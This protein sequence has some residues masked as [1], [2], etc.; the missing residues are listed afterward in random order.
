VFYSSALMTKQAGRM[1]HQFEKECINQM[2]RSTLRT[3]LG[4]VNTK[5]DMGQRYRISIQIG[6][7][8][9]YSKYN[10]LMH[11]LNVLEAYWHNPD[12]NNI[13]VTSTTLNP[14][15]AQNKVN[16]NACEL[17]VN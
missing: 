5:Q 11:Y 1:E 9:T 7:G 3:Y 12:V 16:V 14:I 4:A 6:H 13:Q 17:I 2:A 8:Y 10:T 15:H